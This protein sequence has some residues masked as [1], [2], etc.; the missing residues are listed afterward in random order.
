MANT[1]PDEEIIEKR[2][3][4]PVASACLV[5]AALATLTAVVFQ[6]WEIHY[7]RAD[8]REDSERKSPTPHEVLYKKN[9]GEFKAAVKKVVDDHD[10]PEITLDVSGSLKGAPPG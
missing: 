4:N 5:V 1:T 3:S 8:I 7:V 2:P 10:H 9:L 6:I